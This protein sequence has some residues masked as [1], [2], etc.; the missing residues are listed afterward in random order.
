MNIF[1]KTLLMLAVPAAL[2]AQ[3]AKV[4]TAWRQLQDYRDSKDVSSLMKAKEAIDLATNHED[5]KDKAKTWSYRGQVYYTLFEHALEQETNKAKKAKPAAKDMT[6]QQKA[7]YESEM[8]TKAYGTVST[9][10]YEEAQKSLM[11]LITLDKEK[12]YQMDMVLLARN[13]QAHVNNLASGKFFAGKY[14]EA[15]DYFE[16]SYF[17]TKMS[18]GGKTLDTAALTNALI[19]VQKARKAAD[20]QK[21][22]QKVKEYSG[23]IKEYNEKIINEKIATSYNYV[24]LYDIK[25]ALKDSAGAASTLKQGRLLFPNDVDLL[26]R[27][28]DTYLQRGKDADALANLDKAIEKAPNSVILYM[29]RG[30][31]YDRQ[32]NPRDEQKR[33]LDKPKNYEELMARAESNYKKVTE[34]DAKNTDAWY[35]LGALYNGWANVQ[36]LACDN[37]IKQAAKM[38][39]CEAKAVEKYMKAIDAFEKVTAIN[40]TDKTTMRYLYKLYIRTEQNDKAAKMKEAIDKK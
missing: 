29:A 3:N 39:E 7:D 17:A 19:A 36:L 18:S 9:V 16:A 33:E 38:K 2:S 40:P 11:Q 26:N 8:L 27:E 15:A 4:Q 1:T 23:K 31:V 28:T 6:P 37:L 34:L 21:D 12:V 32:A 25:L 20:D 14:L 35:S 24:S 30:Q 22:E 13:I 10:D 5:T